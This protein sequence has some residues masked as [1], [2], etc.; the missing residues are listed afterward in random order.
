MKLETKAALR[1]RQIK[2]DRHVSNLGQAGAKRYLDTHKAPN[3][4][5]IRG[6]IAG[7]M[8]ATLMILLAVILLSL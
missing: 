6:W 3:S 4:G 2:V 5:N 8:F 1:D 7:A